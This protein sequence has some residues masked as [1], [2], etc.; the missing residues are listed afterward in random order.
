MPEIDIEP[1]YVGKNEKFKF[2]SPDELFDL[3]AGPELKLDKETA[4]KFGKY[5]NGTFR[6]FQQARKTK[7][8]NEENTKTTVSGEF[9]TEFEEEARG[10]DVDLIGYTPVLPDFIFYNLKVYGKNAIVLGMEMKW[11]KIKTAPSIACA[12]SYTHLTL[13]TN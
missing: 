7:Y 11:D 6:G 13:P 2:K 3:S 5:L 1:T 8:G 4:K 9:W 10:M 12:V